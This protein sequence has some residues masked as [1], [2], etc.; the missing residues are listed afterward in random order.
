MEALRAGRSEI[1]EKQCQAWIT[2]TDEEG[3]SE[4]TQPWNAKCCECSE[5]KPQTTDQNCRSLHLDM[6]H[7][8][9]LKKVFHSCQMF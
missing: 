1:C 7:F 2:R 9:H 3:S 5:T 6:R 8:C 4:E